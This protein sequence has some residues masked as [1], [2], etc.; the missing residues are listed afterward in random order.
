MQI[1]VTAN[2]EYWPQ[3][4]PI[5]LEKAIYAPDV[6]ID[7]RGYHQKIKG[8]L[9]KALDGHGYNFKVADDTNAAL[10]F[11]GEVCKLK[12]LHFHARSEHFIEQSDSA[13]EIHLIHEIPGRPTGSRFVVVGVLLNPV[14][15]GAMIKGLAGMNE[16]FQKH[17]LMASDA[18]AP[19]FNSEEFDPRGFIPSKPYRFYRY[20]GSLTT[21]P[22]S[23]IISWVVM[24]DVLNVDETSIDSISKACTHDARALQPL[25]RRFVLRSFK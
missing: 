2:L 10:R 3:Q 21:P 12:Q 5:R 15:G 7:F 8:T 23:E 24:A 6:D 22:Y 18:P 13:L 16:L 25:N 19:E 11:E 1:N 17:A 9:V 4:S 20:E 14:A